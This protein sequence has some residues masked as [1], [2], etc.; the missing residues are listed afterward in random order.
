MRRHLEADGLLG[1]FVGIVEG[2]YAKLARP[3]LGETLGFALPPCLAGERVADEVLTVPQGSKA[4]LELASLFHEGLTASDAQRLS[5]VRAWFDAHLVEAGEAEEAQY[6]AGPD[7]SWC[8][9][10]GA[11]YSA[12]RASRMQLYEHVAQMYAIGAPIPLLARQPPRYLLFFDLDIYGGLEAEPGAS[13]VHHLVWGDG[14]R[15]LFKAIARAVCALYP[16]FAEALE[17]VVFGASGICRLHRRY[18]ASYHLVFPQVVVDRPVK[19]WPGQGALSARPPARHLRVRDHVLHCL[20]E[21]SVEGGLLE[22]LQDALRRCCDATLLD[23][24]Q[25]AGSG[26][27]ELYDDPTYLNDWCEILDEN[28]FWH[29][30]WPES[31]SGLRLPYTDKQPEGQ[32]EGRPKLPLGRWRLAIPCDPREPVAMTPL[33]QLL[34]TDWVLLGDLSNCSA[35]EA[36]PWSEDALHPGVV[37]DECPCP[38]C[39]RGG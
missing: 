27:G 26:N 37:Y 24:G 8:T 20:G 5:E 13:E 11:R 29:E 38:E 30:P 39:R 16:Q 21:D 15:S 14:E 33:P 17:L 23:D 7:G 31:T 4:D 36:T 22:S 1:R 28:P 25:E 9:A 2:V 34:P 12:P 32:P 3:L 35:A 6:C 10:P 19:C 18:K